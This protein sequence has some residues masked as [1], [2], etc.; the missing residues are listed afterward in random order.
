MT[1]PLA[2]TPKIID[3]WADDAQGPVALHLKQKLLPVEVEGRVIYPPTYADIGYNIDTLSDGTKVATIDS[4]GSQA[5]RMEPIFK[6]EPCSSLVPQ[7]RIELHSKEEGEEK[8]VEVRSILDLAHRSAD[9]VVHASPT[10]SSVVAEA[11][12]ALKRRGDAGPLCRIA[13]TSL[14]FGVWDSRGESNEKRPRLVRSIIRA[15]DVEPLH[16]AAQFNSVWKALDDDQ[17]AGLESEA[18]TKKVKLSEKGFK[19][20]PA[21]FRKTSD[22][23]PEF[24]NHAPNPERRVLGGVL[25]NGS[26]ER[27]VTV[28][29][30]ALRALG[31]ANDQETRSIRRYLLALTLMAATAE[32]ELFL[33]EGCH[34]RFADDDRWNTIPRRGDPT[35]VDLASE[36]ARKTLFAYA[37]GIVEPFRSGWPKKL[38]HRFDM[39]EAKKLLAKKTDDEGSAG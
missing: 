19:D 10:L 30:V 35:P 26:I 13:P 29:L 22:G 34:L 11:F 33:R 12:R 28:N 16:A 1:E 31:G 17:K 21:I 32:I 14:V 2:L 20:A 6:I 25:A 7:I 18:R 39:S 3:N 36:D 4:V 27:D 24:R 23:I 37:Q 5:N 38:V 15:W 9:A 8:H